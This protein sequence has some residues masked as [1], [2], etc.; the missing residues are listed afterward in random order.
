[1]A[2]TS[3]SSSIALEI[4]SCR[5]LRVPADTYLAAYELVHASVR[6][7]KHSNNDESNNNNN[8][9]DFANERTTRRVPRNP[10]KG[11]TG[12]NKL[13]C[14]PQFAVYKKETFAI[15]KHN[16]TFQWTDCCSDHGH[17]QEGEGCD[18]VEIS[19]WGTSAPEISSDVNNATTT[20]ERWRKLVNSV[21]HKTRA[22]R[23]P[24]FLGR[25]RL[26]LDPAVVP[27]PAS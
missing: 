1:M 19:V 25:V 18:A 4:V 3:S 17:D 8:H 21:L 20:A 27:A 5:H 6:I 14:N 2:S 15:A 9:S 10:T 23:K 22:A 26:L 7:I 16:N 13:I 24:R 12:T 11:G